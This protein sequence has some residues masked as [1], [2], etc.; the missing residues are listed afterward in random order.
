MS[1]SDLEAV[2]QDAKDSFEAKLALIYKFYPQRIHEVD[3]ADINFA[4]SDSQSSRP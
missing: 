4:A 1:Y 2:A 3:W